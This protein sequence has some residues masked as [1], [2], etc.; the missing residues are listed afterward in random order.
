M[1]PIIARAAGQSD[2]PPLVDLMQEFYAESARFEETFRAY[3]ALK[4]EID[5][6]TERWAEASRV[7]EDLERQL[8]DG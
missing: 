4:A 1:S 2:I 6:K 5:V 8:A 7:L 3:G